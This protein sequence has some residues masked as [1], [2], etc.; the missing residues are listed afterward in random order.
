MQITAQ[1]ISTFVFTS[2]KVQFF[3][4]FNAKF[5]ASSNLLWP[6]SRVCVRSGRESRSFVFLCHGSF[7]RHHQDG[8]II[9]QVEIIRETTEAEKFRYIWTKKSYYNMI[10]W[11]GYIHPLNSTIKFL[12]P[13]SSVIY[14]FKLMVENISK[15][16]LGISRD[17]SREGQVRPQGYKTFFMLSSAETK[18]YSAHKC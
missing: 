2:V 9:F 17:D 7:D 14:T 6:H 3:I 10:T 11:R 15:I 8:S 1:L 18:I 4:L 5:A 12:Y 16:H 13:N